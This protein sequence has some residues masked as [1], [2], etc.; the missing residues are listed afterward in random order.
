MGKDEVGEI[1]EN[2]LTAVFIDFCH[3]PALPQLDSTQLKVTRVEVRHSSH[4]FHLHPHTNF[5]ATSRH[6]KKLKFGTDNQ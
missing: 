5:S 1:R 4:E 6:A 2:D 3:N